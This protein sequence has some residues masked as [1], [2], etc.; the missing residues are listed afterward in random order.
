MFYVT[1]EDY[2]EFYEVKFQTA[3]ECTVHFTVQ[4]EHDIVCIH[5][6]QGRLMKCKQLTPS[7]IEVLL[8]T[9]SD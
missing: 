7:T 8:H 2:Q 1:I 6:D 4:K 9:K 5:N 3:D